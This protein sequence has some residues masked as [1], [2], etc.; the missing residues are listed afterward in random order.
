MKY[1]SSLLETLIDLLDHYLTYP[2]DDLSGE[3]MDLEKQMLI[4]KDFLKKLQSAIF[5][6]F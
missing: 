1:H 3:Q 2:I 4:Q 6:K 5:K